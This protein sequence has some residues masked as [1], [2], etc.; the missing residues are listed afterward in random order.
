MQI[1]DKRGG[2]GR[3][4]EGE[5]PFTKLETNLGGV[6]WSGEG[7]EGGGVKD[8]KGGYGRGFVRVVVFRVAVA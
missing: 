2:E 1:I 7:E 6:G 5:A 3:G 4:G 8:L